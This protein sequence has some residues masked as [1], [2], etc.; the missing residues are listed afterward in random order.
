MSKLLSRRTF[1]KFA[2]GTGV[3]GSLLLETLLAEVQQKGGLSNDTI[4]ALLEINDLGDLR[5]S[6]DELD[7]VKTSFERTLE[8]IRKIRAY[9][10]RQST[11][12]AAVFMV[13]R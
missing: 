6:D 2:A 8:S 4:K 10:L 9:E 13:R 7:K 1:A 3:G 5:L 11:E 12:P